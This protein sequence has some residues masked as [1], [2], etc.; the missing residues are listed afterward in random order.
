LT[1]FRCDCLRFVV[2]SRRGVRQ[3]LRKS[4]SIVNIA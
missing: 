2:G 1:R 3:A 4:R